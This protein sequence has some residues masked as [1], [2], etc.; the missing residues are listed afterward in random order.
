MESQT[1]S[2]LSIQFFWLS[3]QYH[4]SYT[5]VSI[6]DILHEQNGCSLATSLVCILIVKVG[7]NAYSLSADIF[8]GISIRTDL[9]A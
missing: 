8:V 6:C 7:I 4:S 3:L 1:K 9:F 5:Y 2:L